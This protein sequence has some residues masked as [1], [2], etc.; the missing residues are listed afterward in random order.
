MAIASYRYDEAL[1]HLWQLIDDSNALIDV[2]APWKMAKEG[3]KELPPL[4]D[5]LANRVLDIA[6]LLEPFMP[7]S[8]EKIIAAFKTPV[9]K[10]E[11]LFPR[12]APDDRT[13]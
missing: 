1:K 8:S 7:S 2:K 4:L 10:I 3:N 13:P 9:K 5:E 6:T 12:I 11:P